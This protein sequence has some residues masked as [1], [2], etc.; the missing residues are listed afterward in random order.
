[1]LTA[2]AAALIL[3]LSGLG[4][5]FFRSRNSPNRFAPRHLG[6]YSRANVWYPLKFAFL[7]ILLTL[8]PY[9]PKKKN[10][11]GYGNKSHSNT[12]EM[13]S[14]QKLSDHPLAIDA[15]YFNGYSS[16]GT[17]LGAGMQR[18]PNRRCESLLF[19]RLPQF[20]SD[21]LEWP[22]APCTDTFMLGDHEWTASGLKFEMIEP[23]KKWRVTFDGP[24]K[25]RISGKTRHVSFDLEW[26]ADTGCFDMDTD[27][28]KSATCRA[29]AREPWTKDFF[30]LLENMHQTHYE[31]YGQLTGLLHVEG[32]DEPIQL[33]LDSMKDRSYGKYRDWGDFHRYILQYFAFENGDR[34]GCMIVSMPNTMTNLVC[35]YLMN[36]KDTKHAIYGTDKW[37][38]EIGEDSPPDSYEL[39]F[40]A[41]DRKYRLEVE[42]VEKP[43]YYCGWEWQ[44]KLFSTM[45]KAKLDGVPG[46]GMCE[47]E[48]RNFGGRKLKGNTD[49][50]PEQ[51]SN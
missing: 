19:I 16:D 39:L 14:V 12:Q 3:G 32:L 44:A 1:M 17:Y 51:S 35:G 20:E 2:S 49:I 10:S 8:R 7:Y 28:D 13:E 40:C 47:F 26:T 50:E 23:M 22:W 37:L 42:L 15:S 46:R 45:V 27:M 38:Y 9:L 25:H 4:I 24:L 6:V 18:R 11:A 36:G 31:L 41:G 43:L 30:E 5:I 21:I 33:R 48:Y 34:V 29:I